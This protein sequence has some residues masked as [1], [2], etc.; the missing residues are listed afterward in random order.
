MLSS[1]NPCYLWNSYGNMG[2]V[3]EKNQ[4]LDEIP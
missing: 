4:I 3:K 1:N 2:I